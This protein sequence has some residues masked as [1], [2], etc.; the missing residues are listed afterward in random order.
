MTRPRLIRSLRIAWTVGC[1]ILCV[2]LIVLW[3]RSYSWRDL[4]S[5]QLLGSQR[6]STMSMKG[7][8]SCIKEHA[9]H[10]AGF[11]RIRSKLIDPELLRLAHATGMS[12][13]LLY[14]VPPY[15]RSSYLLVPHCLPIFLT[16]VTAGIP[17]FH[18]QFSLRTLLI[19]TTLIAVALG[20]VVIVRH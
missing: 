8:L 13:K 11:C 17:W 7:N 19:A 18:W 2:L 15:N 3:V 5:I 9:P 12:A 20:L 6:L 10:V 1:G 14:R 16:V 4:C